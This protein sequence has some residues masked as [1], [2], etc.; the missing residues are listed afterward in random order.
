MYRYFTKLELNQKNVVMLAL[1]EV[2]LLLKYITCQVLIGVGSSW[3]CW[4]FLSPVREGDAQN[5]TFRSNK[6]V[7]SDF[8]YWRLKGLLCLQESNSGV[9]HCTLIHQC[10]QR[11]GDI[12]GSA[13]GL[14][15]WC[16]C[17]HFTAD[18]YIPQ[19]SKCQRLPKRDHSKDK[20]K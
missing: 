17:T 1:Q 9:L 12:T 19:L 16:S 15:V 20:A 6:S 2:L 4:F 3:N 14:R 13:R 18:S 11:I 8:I 5:N 10:F 7:F